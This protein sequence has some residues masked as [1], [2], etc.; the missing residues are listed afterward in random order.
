M[1][2]NYRDKHINTCYTWRFQQLLSSYPPANLHS[3]KL[4]NLIYSE[5]SVERMAEANGNLSETWKCFTKNEGAGHTC[6]SA[7]PA[8]MDLNKGSRCTTG[9]CVF[10]REHNRL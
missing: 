1:D 4:L 7:A 9:E 6:A 10:R 2:K 3:S 8:C 5:N